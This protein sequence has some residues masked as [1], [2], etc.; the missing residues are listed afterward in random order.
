MTTT[1]PLLIPETAKEKRLQRRRRRDFH[2]AHAFW[3]VRV[4]SLKAAVCLSL[5][6]SFERSS[7]RRSEKAYTVGV[8]SFLF[9]DEFPQKKTFFLMTTSPSSSDSDDDEFENEKNDVTELFESSEMGKGAA[10]IA[11]AD[12][13][14]FVAGHECFRKLLWKKL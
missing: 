7:S 9:S 12:E 1:P 3:V 13:G 4:G 11:G 6:L 14:D 10:D 5:S 8:K 2:R